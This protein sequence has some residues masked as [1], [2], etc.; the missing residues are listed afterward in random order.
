MLSYCGEPE[1]SYMLGYADEGLEQF[2]RQ[3]GM[4]VHSDRLR[5]SVPRERY[6]DWLTDAKLPVY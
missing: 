6:L 1:K 4:Q 2:A 5:I 3:N